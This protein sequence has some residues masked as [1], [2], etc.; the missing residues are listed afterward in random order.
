MNSSDD[1]NYYINI[2]NN[3]MI[4]IY[5][6]IVLIFY[7]T[8]N[9]GNFISILIFSKKS[10][11]KNVCVF[12]LKIY[13]LSSSFYINSTILSTIFS[14]GYNINVKNSN[15][16]LCK[17]YYYVAHVL[18][19]N[20]PSILILASIDRLLISSQNVNTRLY[21]SKRLAYVSISLIA[22]FWISFHSHVL[23][24]VNII[25]YYPSVFICYYDSLKIYRDFVAYST[26]II[27]ILFY[28]FMVV[29]SL[30]A[31]KNVHYIRI[32]P[33][34]QQ[35]NQIR[36]MTK[37]DFQLLRCLYAHDIIFMC[38]GLWIHI[39]NVYSTITK[40]Q[41]RTTK[42]QTINNFIQNLC[43]FIYS[44]SYCMSFF[45]YISIAKTFRQ[46]LKRMI[47]KFFGKR[48]IPLR[49]E[50]NIEINVVVVSTI[51]S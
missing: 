46:E 30:F 16:C 39:Y 12:Y 5:K 31:F 43:S 15:I 13:L 11:K 42:E 20:S 51:V 35:R 48:V 29:L 33:R 26:L 44:S 38:C 28:I 4:S 23:F 22:L 8:A 49:E 2:L 32:I 9:I 19:T 18:A 21:S 47:Y 50:Q 25:E 7:I 34:Q 14:R 1:N 37:K 24:K 40:D 27:N 3:T 6:Y 36:S 17:I 41:I 45:I 10:W